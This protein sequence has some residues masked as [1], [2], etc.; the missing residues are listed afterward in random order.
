MRLYSLRIYEQDVLKHEYVPYK[1]GNVLGL[2]DTV[3]K[4]V[5]TDARNS[6]TPFKIGGMGVEGAEKWLVSPQ[7]CK[8][9]KAVGTVTLSA[10]ASGAVGYKWTKNGEAAIGGAD[11]D[12]TVEWEK[13]GVTDT[14]AVTPVYDVYGVETEGASVSCIVENLSPGTVTVIR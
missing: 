3:D 8:L 11:G 12:L 13:G 14:Y 9:S 6:A 4:V 7:N 10:N 2:Y 5:K 1:K